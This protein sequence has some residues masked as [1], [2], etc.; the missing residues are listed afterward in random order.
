MKYVRNAY[1]VND[2]NNINSSFLN[3]LLYADHIPMWWYSLNR[4]S[5]ITYCRC[6]QKSV[7]YVHSSWSVKTGLSITTAHIYACTCTSKAKYA[8]YEIG[9]RKK[10]HLRHAALPPC[11]GVSIGTQQF[12][13]IDFVDISMRDVVCGVSSAWWL[14]RSETKRATAYTWF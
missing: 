9:T 7:R 14:R 4:L 11:W 10:V 12:R 2:K 6:G 3:L 1:K 8:W 13:A 5:I